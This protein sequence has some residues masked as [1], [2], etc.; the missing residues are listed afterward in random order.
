LKRK[1]I[2]IAVIGTGLVFTAAALIAL[3]LLARTGQAFLGE[4]LDTAPVVHTLET[5]N[6][7]SDNIRTFLS[8]PTAEL[9]GSWKRINRPGGNDWGIVAV[10]HS[11]SLVPYLESL[12]PTTSA[13]LAEVEADL[14]RS[15]FPH[16]PRSS[17]QEESS[18]IQLWRLG[19]WGRSPLLHGVVIK[20]G[21]TVWIIAQTM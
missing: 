12:T 17:A 9:D 2:V 21:E 13:V 16:A 19:A 18:P 14:R 10:D 6:S 8:L 5:T 4:E 1:H 3:F 20:D 7:R 11:G 15:G